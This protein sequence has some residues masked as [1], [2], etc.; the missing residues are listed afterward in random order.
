VNFPGPESLINQYV[1]LRIASALRHSL[2]GE[3]V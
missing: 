3:L 2:R 1:D